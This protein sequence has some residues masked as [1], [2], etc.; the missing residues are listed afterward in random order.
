LVDLDGD[1]RTDIIS[2]SWPGEIYFF[3]RLPDGS[4]AAGQIL[5]DKDG[6]DINVGHASSA[7]AVDWNGDGKIDLLV[8]T[9]SG[10]VFFIANEGTGRELR[11][12]AAVPLQ[13]EGK[14]IQVKGDA[15]P[16][17]ADWDRDGRLDLILGAADGSVV[18]YRNI[19]DAKTPKLGPPQTLVGPSRVAWK[20]DS[21]VGPRDHGIRVKPCVADWN[22]DGKLDLLLGDYCGGF[23]GKTEQTDA[24]KAEEKEANEKLPELNR[25]WSATFAEFRK[26][27]DAPAPGAAAAQA[28]RERELEALRQKMGRLR[29]E[30]VIV[31]EIQ[32]HYRIQ[33][34]AHGYIWL[35]LRK[36]GKATKSP[37]GR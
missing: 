26:L 5:K 4:F 25:K 18:W 11:F 22:G 13:A 19:G 14:A 30:I 34:Q 12:G 24:E 33:S 31:Q 8:G 36:D 37:G 7:F 2:G 29:R 35:F 20:D 17:A 3:R 6:K 21:E 16:V 9:V 28:D 15:A 10:E 32:N 1:G 23:Q 27:R